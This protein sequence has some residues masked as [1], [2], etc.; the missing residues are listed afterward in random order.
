MKNKKILFKK[1]NNLQQ[2]KNRFGNNMEYF[3]MEYRCDKN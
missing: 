2:Q 1:I 3:L